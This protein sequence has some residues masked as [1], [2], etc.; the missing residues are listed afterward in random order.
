MPLNPTFRTNGPGTSRAHLYGT[1]YEG[2]PAPA[3]QDREALCA[4][5]KAPRCAVFML[6]G[7]DECYNGWITEYSGWLATDH[8]SHKRS[9]YVCIDD[10]ADLGGSTTNH[11]GALF[12]PVQTV[13]GALPCGYY[14]NGRD[15]RCAVCS[16]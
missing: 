10:N 12:Y 14:P 4:V 2:P 16:Q 7:R 8:S 6:P 15:T 11:N 1:E 13:C 5:C 9:E 3:V